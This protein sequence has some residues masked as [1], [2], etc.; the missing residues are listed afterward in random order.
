M[1]NSGTWSAISAGLTRFE[2][3]S[4]RALIAVWVG[5]HALAVGALVVVNVPDAACWAGIGYVAVS[6]F[7]AFFARRRRV[8]S[9]GYA[10]ES[11]WWLSGVHGRSEGWTALGAFVSRPVVLVYLRRGGRR[12]TL[13][14]M[15]DAV[16]EAVHRRLRVLLGNG[17]AFGKGD[18]ANADTRAR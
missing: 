17:Y 1:R 4:S 9:A 2:L 15:R 3:Q 10:P 7:F 8:D 5:L 6:C 11:G 12:R 16:D 14:V 18:W 13:V